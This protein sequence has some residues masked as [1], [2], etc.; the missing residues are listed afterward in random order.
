MTTPGFRRSRISLSRPRVLRF[1]IASWLCG[2]LLAAPLP[3]VAA[4]AADSGVT[5]I[6]GDPA[7][8]G[9]SCPPPD[10]TRPDPS[11]INVDPFVLERFP[12][13]RVLSQLALQAH[14]RRTSAV[15]LYQRL[16][17]SMDT[18]SSGKFK[19]PHCDAN[20]DTLNGFPLECPR[21]EVTLVDTQ[22]ELFEPL[23]LVNRFD[24][25][26]ADGANCGEYR[27]VYGMKPFSEQNRNLII[28]EGVLPNPN[29]SCGIE[30]CRPVVEFWESL[31]AYDPASR[32]ERH[33]LASRLE[34]F[35]FLG[36][37]GFGPVVEPDHFGLGGG[38]GYGGPNGGQIRTNMFVLGTTW[39]LR[40]FHLARAC[41]RFGC[42]LYFDPAAVGDNP[43]PQMFDFNDQSS[44]AK[45][46]REAFIP[47]V[48]G[49][50][51]DDVSAISLDMDPRFNAAQSTSTGFDDDYAVQM[52]NGLQE[53]PNDFTRAIRAELTRL[54]RTD[55]SPLDV[56]ERASSQS[57]AGC[58][59][60]SPGVPLSGNGS[61]GPVWPDVRPGG[62]VHI[63]EDR[64]LSPALWCTFLPF[65]KSVLDAVYENRGEACEASATCATS[66]PVRKTIVSVGG[67]ERHHAP[68]STGLTIAG[69]PFGP[70]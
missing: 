36:V 67:R 23:A 45:D 31:S 34:Y 11:L 9:P 40:E 60:V 14:T 63:D 65:R 29:P 66:R 49:L 64:N 53:G 22:P 58:H 17:D 15:E 42:E 61:S 8:P 41:D 27:I 57:C 35:Y 55:V 38:R 48:E 3:A 69:R 13:R 51:S 59:M 37:P 26:P 33:A 43:Y 5:E 32:A 47:H 10:G 46:F 7:D 21:P 39:Q 54:G 6:A 62:F 52:I 16:W 2:A 24:L 68:H 19:G 28:M 44:V 12:L 70:N 1:R 4:E 25:A 50:L 56:A 30:A 18:A 20:D